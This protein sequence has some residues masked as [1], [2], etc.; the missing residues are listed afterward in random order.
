MDVS[1]GFKTQLAN[2]VYMLV[3]GCYNSSIAIDADRNV[4]VLS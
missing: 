2:P 1:I 4:R 3:Y